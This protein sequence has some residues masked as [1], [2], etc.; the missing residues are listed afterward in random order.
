MKKLLGQKEDAK[1]R[2]STESD[3]KEHE[4]IKFENNCPS[5]KREERA[6]MIEDELQ[7][8]NPYE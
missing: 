4:E 1:S 2:D 6:D 5:V 7:E 8:S 3:K